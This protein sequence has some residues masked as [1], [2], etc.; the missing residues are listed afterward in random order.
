MES[1]SIPE[2]IERA[3]NG[4]EVAVERLY[5]LQ[6]RQVYGLCVRMTSDQAEAED[7]TQEVFLQAFRKLTTFRGEAAFSTWIYRIATNVVLMRLR[8]KA[9]PAVSLE[10]MTRPNGAVSGRLKSIR[11]T[12]PTRSLV[13]R[14]SVQQAL[15]QLPEGYKRV[16][17]LHDIQG[18]GHSEIA[19]LTGRPVGNSKSQLHRARQRLR[20]LLGA[21]SAAC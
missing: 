15:D 13:D 20:Q 14:M 1:G 19:E 21:E 2:T 10:E 11:P 17:V 8:K 4:D 5:H 9:H 3:R 16:V 6:S 12:E 18:Y 7:L